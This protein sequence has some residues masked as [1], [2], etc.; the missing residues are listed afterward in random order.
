MNRH[1]T[2]CQMLL[3]WSLMA[4]CALLSKTD[5]M[6]VRYFEAVEKPAPE[7][8]ASASASAS[9]QGP[10]LRLGLVKAASHLDRRI[11]SRRGAHE[12]SYHERL[13]WTER[14]EEYLRRALMRDLYEQ[15][16]FTRVVSGAAP[17]L[18]V[19]LIAFEELEQSGQ[20]RGRI[21]LQAVLHDERVQL[22]QET[23]SIETK[24]DDSAED[25]AEAL[26]SALGEA[27]GLATKRVTERTRQVLAAR[28]TPARI[29]P[30][31]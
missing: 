17:T 31:Q 8:S 29:S 20:R 10:P 28:T 6:E 19:E 16:G 12:L 22:A 27:L 30:D 21:E 1:F 7:A 15:A 9:E 18:D 25:K 4:G 13:R 24:V 2:I 26:V 14:P 11:V 23:I 3:C 5:P